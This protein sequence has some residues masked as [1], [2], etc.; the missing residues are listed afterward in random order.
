M[1]GEAVFDAKHRPRASSS[2]HTRALDG[3]RGLAILAVL[4]H[5]FTVVPAG[6]AASIWILRFAEF[7]AHGVDLFFVL[8]G[9][10]ITSQLLRS[11]LDSSAIREFYMRRALRIIPLYFA[12]LAV[13]F[14]LLPTA[15]RATGFDQKLSTQIDT[16]N[17]WPWYVF[18]VSNF[19]NALDGRFTNPA[20]DVSWSLAIE[21][22][23]YLLWPWVIRL[24]SRRELKRVLWAVIL[25]SPLLRGAA[26]AAGANWIQVLVLPFLRA[27]ALLWGAI[28]AVWIDEKRA[29][30]SLAISALR[31]LQAVALCVVPFVFLLLLAGNWDRQN[32]FTA[33]LG[34]SLIGLVAAGAFACVLTGR[35]DGRLRRFLETPTLVFL[36]PYAYGL[37]LFHIPLRALLR[38]TV[39]K[40]SGF[41]VWPF[42]PVGGQLV[43]YLLAGV[44]CFVPAIVSWHFWEKRFVTWGH[45]LTA[46][47]ASRSL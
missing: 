1:T 40:P 44:V 23:F 13:V 17:N 47:A 33:T 21:M 8:S 28:V 26:W 31:R 22:Q 24:C 32:A 19:R 30:L 34:Y 27:D 7:G 4:L 29:G 11:R 35:G 15:L 39:F 20:L 5:H 3:V 18:F 2:Q 12:V 6:G 46:S 10:L 9:F 41:A 42:P 36:S 43:F 25:I 37:Y 45:R 16:A 38:D 14:L